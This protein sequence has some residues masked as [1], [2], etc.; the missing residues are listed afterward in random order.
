MA[1]E[2]KAGTFKAK[3]L[4]YGLA[5]GKNAPQAVV[6]IKF[7]DADKT[8]HDLT[9]Y[10]SLSDKAKKFTCASLVTMGFQGDDIRTMVA[11]KGSGVL[12]ETK[13]F[14][15]VVKWDTYVNTDTGEEKGSFKIAFINEVG[16]S[17]FRNLMSKGEVALKF[18]GMNFGADFAAAR[19]GG[20]PP[21][22]APPAAPL[23]NF[24]PGSQ[25]AAPPMPPPPSFN[26]NE[27]IPF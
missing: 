2:I 20:T 27:E 10:G 15:V 11:G 21:P 9:W 8:T 24:A 4:D 23:Q 17:G 3:V 6:M 19:V 7:Q 13:V 22:V 25:Q 14:E 12:S 16:A 26:P 5:A 18:Q 1:N